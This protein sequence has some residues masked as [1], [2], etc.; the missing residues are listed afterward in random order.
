MPEPNSSPPPRLL[1]LRKRPDFLRAATGVKW[2]APAFV[3]Q[4]YQRIPSDPNGPRLGFTASRRVGGAVQ[5]NFARRRLKEATRA[6]FAGKARAGTD[7]VLIARGTTGGHG[8]DLILADLDRALQMVHKRLD[9]S[10][11]SNKTATLK[12][13]SRAIC[14]PLKQPGQ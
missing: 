7:Y 4:A 10:R 14:A 3:L 1:R 9:A 12:S 5:R 6:V 8:F 13:S 11:R 2:V